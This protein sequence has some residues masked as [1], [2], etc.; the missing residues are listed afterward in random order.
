MSTLAPKNES[1]IKTSKENKMKTIRTTEKINN[2]CKMAEIIEK[3]KIVFIRVNT[4]DEC[5]I[6]EI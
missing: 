2:I 5:L 1:K 3:S 6:I 4:A